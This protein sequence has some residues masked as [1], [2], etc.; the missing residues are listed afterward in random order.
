MTPAEAAF[1][2]AI[3]ER[4]AD[5]TPR[6]IYA[7]WLEEQGR[8]EWAEF[9]RAAIAKGDDDS[10]AEF[11]ELVKRTDPY[12]EAE[13]FGLRAPWRMTCYRPLHELRS[14]HRIPTTLT[15]RGF[16]AVVSCTAADWL[17]HAATITASQP[18]EM[19]TLTTVLPRNEMLAFIRDTPVPAEADRFHYNFLWNNYKG[20]DRFCRYWWHS[21]KFHLPPD[22]DPY[23]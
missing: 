19:V 8:G 18:I 23:Q 6:L 11:H 12:G 3:I 5:D 13:V 7:D 10:Q 17:A 2:S 15:R 20:L 22:P 21:I 14:K 16:I 1:L 9:I 4:P